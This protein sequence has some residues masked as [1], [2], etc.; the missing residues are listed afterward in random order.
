M[1]L[2]SFSSTH[3][4]YT[5]KSRRG[6]DLDKSPGKD[7]QSSTPARSV[8]KFCW[9]IGGRKTWIPGRSCRPRLTNEEP[10]LLSKSC[11]LFQLGQKGSLSIF[12]HPTDL[13]NP[14]QS[15]VVHAFFSILS[16]FKMLCIKPYFGKV[17]TK[18]SDVGWRH[19]HSS[20]GAHVHELHK[21]F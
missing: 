2:A 6:P 16:Y 14:H 5:N 19:L 18:L 20:T 21:S 17:W 4:L 3:F 15:E 7:K 1:Q 10:L 13:I 12:K 9:S 11:T 8:Y